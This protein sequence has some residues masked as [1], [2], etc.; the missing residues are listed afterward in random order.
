MPGFK[1]IGSGRDICDREC[2]SLVGHGKK[3]MIEHMNVAEH[4]GMVS[5]TSFMIPVSLIFC[6]ASRIVLRNGRDSINTVLSWRYEWGI[7]LRLRA[8]AA[9][10]HANGLFV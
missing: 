10:Y 1:H 3:G 9:R 2:S 8:V 7:C 4:P 6:V 5:H